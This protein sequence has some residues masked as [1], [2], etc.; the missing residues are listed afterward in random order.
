MPPK[1]A[2]AVAAAVFAAN[3][4]PAAMQPGHFAVNVPLP[5]IFL[6]E[7]IIRRDSEAAVADMGALILSTSRRD[8]ETHVV[9]V[10]VSKQCV[11]PH[12]IFA[13]SAFLFCDILRRYAISLYKKENPDVKV[14]EAKAIGVLIVRHIAEL[15]ITRLKTSI[16]QARAA[17]ASEPPPEGEA[18]LHVQ[19][20]SA[21]R[22]H[23]LH[24]AIDYLSVALRHSLLL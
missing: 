6:P 8:D 14:P 16:E 10:S 7:L 2:A 18:H 9:K 5:G 3:S 22:I 11:A 20:L 4:A 15:I 12:S 1:S 23:T 13:A 24:V 17:V 19:R 21:R